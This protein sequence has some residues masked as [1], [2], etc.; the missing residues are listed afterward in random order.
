MPEQDLHAAEADHAEEVLDM[1]LPADH[2]PTKMMQPSEK[3]FHSPASTIATQ[4]T[5]V[6]RWRSPL[7]P[8]GCDH[9]DPVALG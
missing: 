9:L 2:E 3:S 4:W 8:M 6:L 5:P 1:A 7:S